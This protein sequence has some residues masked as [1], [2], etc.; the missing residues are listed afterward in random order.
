MGVPPPAFNEN[1]LRILARF[2][3]FPRGPFSGLLAFVPKL[4]ANLNVVSAQK[5]GNLQG[6]LAGGL[7]VVQ[8]QASVAGR[9]V[10]VAVV[11]ENHPSGTL[12]VS[13]RVRQRNTVK[14]QT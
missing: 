10:Q 8:R 12:T 2:R 5:L 11:S 4:I 9:D 7:H 13:V 14:Y 6:S 1:Q 3:Y